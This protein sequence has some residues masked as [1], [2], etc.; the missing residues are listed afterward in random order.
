MDN[1]PSTPH[2]RTGRAGFNY[3]CLGQA[4]EQ[5]RSGS[6]YICQES[7]LQAD[8]NVH[9][10]LI[11]ERTSRKHKGIW[12]CEISNRLCLVDQF[13]IFFINMHFSNFNCFI[14]I[15]IFIVIGSRLNQNETIFKCCL[16]HKSNNI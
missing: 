4:H 14:I 12:P 5:E 1:H 9:Y 3:R 11:L 13:A 7:K 10:A 2:A 15:F 8:Q 6:L 16:S